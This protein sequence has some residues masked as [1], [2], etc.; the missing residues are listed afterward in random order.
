MSNNDGKKLCKQVSLKIY[1][2]ITKKCSTFS[3]DLQASL[4]LPT[5]Y[6]FEESTLSKQ[7]KKLNVDLYPVVTKF[8][9]KGWTRKEVLSGLVFAILWQFCPI[10]TKP[11]NAS[12]ASNRPFQI[13]VAKRGPNGGALCLAVD[14]SKFGVLQGANRAKVEPCRNI[15]EQQFRTVYVQDGYFRVQT[16]HAAPDGQ[17]KCL[18]TDVT[19]IGIRPGANNSYFGTCRNIEEQMY[20]KF[21]HNP[22]TGRQLLKLSTKQPNYCLD[23]DA[24]KYGVLPEAQFVKF[25]ECRP[26]DEQWL[27]FKSLTNPTPVPSG[28]RHLVLGSGHA[29][30][31]NFGDRFR[32]AQ[33][34]APAAG[35]WQATAGDVDQFFRFELQPDGSY[36][37]RNHKTG[38]C[39]DSTPN[40]TFGTKPIMIPCQKGNPNQLWD[41]LPQGNNVYLLQRKGT[42][43]CL[44]STGHNADGVHTH[45]WQCS[46]GNGNQR[47][48]SVVVTAPDPAP[49]PR[50][51]VKL[52]P[53]VANRLT[54]IRTGSGYAGGN[55]ENHEHPFLFLGEEFNN[56]TDRHEQQFGNG[57][58]MNRWLSMET[59]EHAVIGA[60]LRAMLNTKGEVNFSGT[61]YKVVGAEAGLGI[62]TQYDIQLDVE[63]RF[64][65]KIAAN[66]TNIYDQWHVWYHQDLN[67]CV[68]NK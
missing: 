19:K 67:V 54:L 12:V 4:V 47:F 10:L 20:S 59:K 6:S 41:P 49:Q 32:N 58:C 26:I 57:V 7:L 29:L 42:N 52:V 51:V 18:D 25:G 46:T 56:P 35:L 15:R 48:A 24:S 8:L 63:Y 38:L 13:E 44:D 37:L 62:E 68:A 3:L 2:T 30:N 39:L 16:V 27:G 64:Y 9:A 28:W 33:Y 31:T 1:L 11:A 50:K 53:K 34:N 36:L 14:I 55:W 40:V 43:F 45:L 60:Q 61:V 65:S 5:T 23:I 66:G 21:A 22:Q 17:A